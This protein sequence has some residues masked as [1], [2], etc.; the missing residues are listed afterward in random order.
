MRVNH[1]ILLSLLACVMTRASALE[2][3]RS[4]VDE[5]ETHNTVTH[6]TISEIASSEAVRKLYP[7]TKLYGDD[8][9]I[10]ILLKLNPQ[11]KNEDAIFPDQAILITQSETRVPASAKTSETVS[12]KAISPATPST[13]SPANESA[14]P[15]VTL[16]RENKSINA[17]N[18][19]YYS[20][21]SIAPAL[22]YY[23]LNETD[24]ASGTNDGALSNA[25]PGF[26][27]AWE[28]QMG[29][30]ASAAFTVDYRS[31]SWQDPIG[32]SMTN[33][34][35]SFT[36]FN[37]KFEKGIT[38][39]FF[40]SV[41]VGADEIVLL[42]AVTPTQLEMDKISVFDAQV[43]IAYQIFAMGP[44]QGMLR[45]DG[46]VTTGATTGDAVVKTGYLYS[47]GFELSQSIHSTLVKGGIRYQGNSYHTNFSDNS[48][49]SLDFT[50]GVSFKLGE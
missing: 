33:D 31:V 44:Y 41:Q 46:G 18:T 29:K 8:G 26:H 27:L 34:H 36:N 47:A 45:A 13:N 12:P 28:P 38:D 16:P 14:S 50:L 37:V 9:R 3:V 10:A 49:Q 15:T 22:T 2:V 35:N 19:E 17:D 23:R 5:S 11:I 48:L 30:G 6:E 1:W 43:G 20:W 42:R 4:A 21:F 40:T 39:R 25:S 7:G 24:V 32:R